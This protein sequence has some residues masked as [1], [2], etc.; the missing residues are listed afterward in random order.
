MGGSTGGDVGVGII[1]DA[2]FMDREGL[3]DCRLLGDVF[4]WPFFVLM[5]SGRK[6]LTASALSPGKIAKNLLL[7]AFFQEEIFG[8]KAA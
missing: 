4:I 1:V 2:C 7:V 3:V 8:L 5:E 6:F